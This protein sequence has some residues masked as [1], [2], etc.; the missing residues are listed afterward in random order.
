M[1]ARDLMRRLYRGEC[2]VGG[3]RR[4]VAAFKAVTRHRTPHCKRHRTPR[5]TEALQSA[6]R[7]MHAPDRHAA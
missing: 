1:N 7:V 2:S 4:H 5:C 6:K 3:V